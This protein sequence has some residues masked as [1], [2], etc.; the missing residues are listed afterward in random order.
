MIGVRENGLSIDN[1]SIPYEESFENYAEGSAIGLVNF[2]DAESGDA[3]T[4]EVNNYSYNVARPIN[5]IHSKVLNLETEGNMLLCCVTG[6]SDHVWIDMMVEIIPSEDTPYIEGGTTSLAI[7]MNATSNLCAYARTNET[8]EP[9]FV[10]SDT[11]PEWNILHRLTMHLLYQDAPGDCFFAIYIDQVLVEWPG[12]A[13]EPMTIP[14]SGYGPWLRFGDLPEDRV[15]PG[16]AFNGTGVLDDITID[17]HQRE[18][19]DGVRARIDPGYAISWRSNN[20]R[21]YKVEY[22]TNLVEQSWQPLQGDVTGNGITNTVYDLEPD[23]R[24]RFYRVT[25]VDP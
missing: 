25:P 11:K 1:T 7:Y 23:S 20:G 22:C 19:D 14:T 3:S 2:W 8:G 16:L 15:F 6:S 12:G 17:D 13:Q 18:P 5:T 24:S 9:Y 21:T 10:V 4:I